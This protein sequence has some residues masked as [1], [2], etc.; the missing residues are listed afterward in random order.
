MMVGHPGEKAMVHQVMHH[1]IKSGVMYMFDLNNP[2]IIAR[3]LRRCTAGIDCCNSCP[4]G[5]QASGEPDHGC[6]DE[7]HNAA[8]RMIEKQNKLERQV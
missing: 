7:L 4:Y 5:L 6:M 8:A 2:A 1:F 3:W